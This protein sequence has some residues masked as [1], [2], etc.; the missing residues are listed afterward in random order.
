MKRWKL[1]GL[2]LYSVS[3][4]SLYAGPVVNLGAA[5]S[6][7]VLGASTV[8]NT[9]PTTINGDLGLYP[10]TSITDLPDITLT[11]TVHQTDAVAHQAQIDALAAYNYLRGL[12]ATEDDLSGLDLGGL[13]LT[14]GVYSFSSSAELTG[15]LTLDAQGDP[16]ALFIFLIGTTLG[17]A[18]GDFSSVVTIHEANCCNVYWQVGS[19]ATIGTYTSFLGTIIAHDT[20]TLN[21]G[22]SIIDGRALALNYAVNLD[23]NT[24]SNAVCI[25][26]PGTVALLGAGLFGLVLLGRRSRKRAA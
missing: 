24:I 26:E 6:F 2:L 25:P 10:G 3:A 22:A 7:A 13:I 14:P 1:Y 5:S 23:T 17:T 4:L 18:D 15:T 11:G 20:I 8:T 19:S 12:T 21:T 9:G 16:N